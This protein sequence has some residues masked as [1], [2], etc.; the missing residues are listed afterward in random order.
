MH[1]SI[2][3]FVEQKIDGSF[4]TAFWTAKRKQTCKSATNR[5]PCDDAA[6]FFLSSTDAS[7]RHNDGYLLYSE[8]LNMRR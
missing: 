2:A 3:L 6:I 1:I 4:T 5:L 7:L 8:P